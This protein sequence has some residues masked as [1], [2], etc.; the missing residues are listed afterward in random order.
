MKLLV[1]VPNWLGDAVM[2]IPAL[3]AVRTR[4][5]Q[6][7]ITL[8][9]RPWILSIYAGQGLADWLG[10][11]QGDRAENLA[12]QPSR[13]LHSSDL[14]MMK[15]DCALLLQNAF[16]AAWTAWRAGIPQRIG[17]GRDGRSLLLT[18]PIAVPR[19]GEIP[20]HE[21]YYY[22]ELLR[23]A[24]WIDALPQV[25]EIRLRV[26]EQSKS[27]AESVLAAAGA[28][29]SHRR[30]RVAIAPGAS[31]G[32]AKCWPVERFAALGDRLVEGFSAD[33]I[34][35]G[36]AGERDV[37]TRI[38]ARMK[39]KPVNLAG[40]T[41]VVDLPALLAACDA[42]IGNDSGAMHVAAAVGLP[43]VA[44]F[45]PTDPHGTAPVTPRRTLVQ[46]HVFCSPCF[47]RHCP[48]DHRCMKRI[49]VEDVLAAARAWLTEGQNPR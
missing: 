18:E 24:G 38:A 5:P 11:N 19:R 21:S 30:L 17:Y 9:G 29:A 42:F 20:V 22:L 23:R 4:W 15:F 39:S 44:I 31:Y 46:K 8:L 6:A 2:C 25:N 45:G 34:L 35:F 16:R 37:A 36:A 47:L 10:N 26:S 28:D 48:I 3:A 7:Q 12:G 43:V 27:R 14:R 1:R 40:Q 33:V 49:A 41:Q 13:E 32:S